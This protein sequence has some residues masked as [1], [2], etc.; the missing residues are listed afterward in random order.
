MVIKRSI[1]HVNY[2]LF[3]KKPNSIQL[4]NLAVAE[5]ARTMANCVNAFFITKWVIIFESNLEIQVFILK[6]IALSEL[7]YHL[8]LKVIRK[9]TKGAIA[10]VR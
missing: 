4:K 8:L 9:F 2:Y 10:T 6:T 3:S 1:K 5:C 7:N